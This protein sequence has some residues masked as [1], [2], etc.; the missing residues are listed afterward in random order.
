VTVDLTGVDDAQCL[1]LQLSNIQPGNGTASVPINILWGDVNGI[2]VVNGGDYLA[3]RSKLN[4]TLDLTNFQY[5]VGCFGI[6]NGGDALIVR[7]LL[8]TSLP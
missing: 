6:V 7:S 5:D 3:T 8:N 1:N 4:S 2:G